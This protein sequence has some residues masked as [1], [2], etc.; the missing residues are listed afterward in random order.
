[1]PPG[2]VNPTP[3]SSRSF[4]RIFNLRPFAEDSPQLQEALLEIG[5]PGGMLD[6]NDDLSRGPVD[7]ILDP[8]LRVNNPDHPTHSAGIT[9]MGQFLDHDMTFDT[10]STL[11][12]ATDPRST[13]NQRTPTFDLDSVY[14]NG[15]LVSRELYDSVDGIKLKLETGGRFEDLP[16]GA[17]NVAIVGDPRNDEN[18]VVCGIHLAMMSFHNQVVDRVR[19]EVPAG[20]DA[21]EVFHRA[22]RQVT[23]H[24]QW[25][26][27][28]EFLP[29]FVGQSLVDDIL[30][31]GRRYFTTRSPFMP[32]EFQG[33]A[34]R[35]GHSMVRPS[36]RANQGGGGAPAFFGMV[37]DPSQMGNPDPDDL[38]G[39]CRAPRRFIGWETFFDFDDGEVRR[40]KLIDTTLSTPLFHLPSSTIARPPGADVGPTSLAQRNLLRHITWS[41]PSGQALARQ[42]GM[43]S[44]SPGDLEDLS[45]F[46]LGLES[47]SP[48][49]FY[50]LRE[51][52]VMAAGR[53]P[54]NVG[55]RIAVAVMLGLLQ[56]DRAS[57][58]S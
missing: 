38:S 47:S 30:A 11:G 14:G 23:W 10:T 54:E 40:N 21:M 22:R 31:R 9:F 26:I 16:R 27:L 28:H 17:D 52:E 49:W 39:R 43:A 58:L 46:G 53:Q 35:F 34:Y 7:L 25:L 57:H 20:T 4:G 8:A 45:G 42:M 2:A 36:Y 6:A 44:L 37:F 12:Q 15:P 50:V 41:L 5:K 19:G 3:G 13:R 51:A 1:M 48:L 29:L 18:L 24:Y 56:S 33:A 55:G 32:I